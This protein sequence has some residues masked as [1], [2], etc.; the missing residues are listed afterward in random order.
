EGAEDS[1][2]VVDAYLRAGQARTWQRELVVAA[3][4]A[5]LTGAG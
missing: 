5:A 3:L 4:A 2:Q 1:V